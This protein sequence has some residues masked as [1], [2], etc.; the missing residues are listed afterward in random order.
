VRFA[1]RAGS[2]AGQDPPWTSWNARMIG[3]VPSTQLYDLE[4]DIG[5]KHDVAAGH[6]DAVERLMKLVEQAREDLGDYNRIGKGA[7]F[8]DK[9][10]PTK[11]EFIAPRKGSKKD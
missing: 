10:V 8:F 3:A 7:R 5:E 4:T 6:P 2:T 9:P 1:G 11:R